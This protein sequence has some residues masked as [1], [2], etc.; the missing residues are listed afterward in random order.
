VKVGTYIRA[1]DAERLESRGIDP[2]PWIR[3]L[4][5]DALEALDEPQGRAAAEPDQRPCRFCGRVS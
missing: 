2:A 1:A 4:V 5:K 3:Q